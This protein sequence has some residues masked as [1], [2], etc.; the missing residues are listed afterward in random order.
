MTGVGPLAASD[1]EGIVHYTVAAAPQGGRAP[2]GQAEGWSSPP[3]LLVLS[4]FQRGG[5]FGILVKGLLKPSSKT[6]KLACGWKS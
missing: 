4:S 6:I 5:S 1:G 2:T 3:K